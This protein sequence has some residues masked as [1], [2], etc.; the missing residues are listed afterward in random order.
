M[1]IGA[2]PAG[3]MAAITAAKG[4]TNTFLL[5][6]KNQIGGKIVV[7]GDGKGNLSNINLDQTYYHSS[8]P[9]FALP[10][11][12][13][14]G[15]LKTEQFFGKLGIKLYVN[16]KGRVYPYSREATIIQKALLQELLKV[17][18]KIFTGV[19][20]QK[21][22]KI[23]PYFEIC[24]KHSHSW[25][26][27]RLILATGGLAAPQLGA[28]GNGYRWAEELG[29]KSIPQFPSLVQLS[30]YLPKFALLNKLKLIRV[31][32]TLLIDGQPEET[33]SGDLLF[34]YNGLSGTTI[35][36]L[37][38]LASEALF[39][40]RKV[41]IKINMVPDLTSQ[42]LETF[43][44]KQKTNN[45]DKEIYSLLLGILPEKMVQYLLS[46]HGMDYNLKISMLTEKEIKIIVEEMT[47]LSIPIISTQSWKYAQVTCG[48]ISVAEVNPDS[49]ESKIVPNLYFAGEILDVDGDCGGYNLQWAWSSGFLAGITINEKAIN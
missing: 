15:F 26:T 34:V 27:Q 25:Y 6:K 1:I 38:R 12:K 29:H 22:S 17:K 2:G 32:V 31:C 28:T 47:N 48:G 20:I 16:S 13:K 45:P 36:S 35:Y 5:E 39:Q 10:A 49:M 7:T 21:I 24:M 9:G 30:A 33:S 42:E 8:Y 44:L 37:S 43:F 40:N 11:L 19:D 3:I 23:G 18:V 4:G 14:F 41:T 46:I